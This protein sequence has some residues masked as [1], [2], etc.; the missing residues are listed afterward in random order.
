MPLRELIRRM[1]HFHA[2]QDLRMEG[3]RQTVKIAP[4]LNMDQSRGRILGAANHCSL[5]EM[6]LGASTGAATRRSAVVGRHSR[7]TGQRRSCDPELMDPR[8][9]PD[10]YNANLVPHASDSL[11]SPPGMAKVR[12]NPQ[13]CLA[14]A[15][16][17]PRPC[18]RRMYCSRSEG[19]GACVATADCGERWPDQGAGRS[20]RT[21]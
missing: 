10:R 20:V 16:H 13:P 14:I 19:L 15:Q 6:A 3:K 18:S 12:M 5:L 17:S 4:P 21:S 8:R 11:A 9:R 2:G 1:T 7:M